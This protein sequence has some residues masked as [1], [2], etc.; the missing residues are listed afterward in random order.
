[1]CPGFLLD[2]WIK[3]WTLESQLCQQGVCDSL[4]CHQADEERSWQPPSPVTLRVHE[5]YVWHHSFA[6]E[7]HGTQDKQ[8]TQMKW[9]RKML[10]CIGAQCIMIK[11]SLKITWAVKV[12]PPTPGQDRTVMGLHSH[13]SLFYSSTPVLC[14]SVTRNS[15]GQRQLCKYV[16]ITGK[17]KLGSSK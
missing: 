7:G 5:L 12:Q 14:N 6:A 11:S 4:G 13:R 1:M 16:G 9:R 15:A 2:L 3:Y 17:S 10:L 8:R